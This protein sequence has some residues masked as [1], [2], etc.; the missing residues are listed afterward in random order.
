MLKQFT[1]KF[2]ATDIMD[3]VLFSAEGM[4]EQD[5]NVEFSKKKKQASQTSVNKI[6]LELINRVTHPYTHRDCRSQHQC[7]SQR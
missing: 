4:T 2:E 1:V 3:L 5:L 7:L 6:S